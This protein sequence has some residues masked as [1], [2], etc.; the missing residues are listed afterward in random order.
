MFEVECPDCLEAI[1]IATLGSTAPYFKTYC[2]KHAPCNSTVSVEADPTVNLNEGWYIGTAT[3]KKIYLDNPIDLSIDDVAL[4]L[5]NICRWGGHIVR[6]YSVAQHCIAVAQILGA[7]AH[8]DHAAAYNGLMHDAAEMVIGDIPRPLAEYL[9]APFKTLKIR[10]E[11]CFEKVFNFT[12]H[13]PKVKFVDGQMLHMEAKIFMRD[14]DKRCQIPF[15]LTPLM[16]LRFNQEIRTVAVL[17]RPEVERH[18]LLLYEYY[19]RA[20]S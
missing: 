15:S 1:Q 2:D 4:S 20:N 7:G 6:H 12:H 10:I 9:G 19:R 16:E 14:L 5:S 13:D 18:F 3:G 11:D 17:T 8:G